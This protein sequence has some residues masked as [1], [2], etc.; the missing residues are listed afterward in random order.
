MIPKSTLFLFLS[1]WTT[2]LWADPQAC[3]GCNK[4]PET[5]A[6]AKLGQVF[7]EQLQTM[8]RNDHALIID[9]RTEAEWHA[10]GIIP[11]S[12][13]LQSFNSDGQFD[14]AK[15]LADLQKL[16][17]S[18]DQAVILVCRSGNRSDKVGEFLVRQ[19]M[20]NVY[21]LNNGIQSWIKSGHP[22]KPD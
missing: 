19:G 22:V 6:A 4:L 5:M 1:L 15:W 21:H 8:Q 10:T 18:P 17:T 13:K 12:Q 16:K 11:G 2:L 14:S 3:E 20:P 9:I 7:S